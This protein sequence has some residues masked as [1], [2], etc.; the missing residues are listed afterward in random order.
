MVGWGSCGSAA[1]HL[2][3]EAQPTLA[4]Q[5]IK[6]KL[7]LKAVKVVIIRYIQMFEDCIIWLFQRK[8]M[9]SVY[10]AKVVVA[11]LQIAGHSRNPNED[12][13]SGII[14]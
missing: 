4:L 12:T 10:V 9:A 5:I 1:T 11:Y 2:S 13:I 8:Y 3:P 7:L 14:S 6:S